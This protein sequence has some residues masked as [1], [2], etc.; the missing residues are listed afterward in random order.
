MLLK[1]NKNLKENIPPT[2]SYVFAILDF[3]NVPFAHP[4]NPG[5]NQLLLYARMY[6]SVPNKKTALFQLSL[7]ISKN[8]KIIDTQEKFLI[9][10]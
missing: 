2:L 5:F 4:P 8:R 10:F 9:L 3:W 1:L 7:C 6:K